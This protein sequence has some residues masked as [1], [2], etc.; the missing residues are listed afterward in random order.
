MPIDFKKTEKEFYLPKTSPTIVDIPEMV[1]IVVDGIGD[2]NTSAEYKDA[3]ET[4]YG[5]SY[6]IKMSKTQPQGHF[7]Y[8]VPPLEGLWW[9]DDKWFNGKKIIDKSKLHWSAMIR[10]PAFVTQDVFEL[11]KVVLAKKKPHINT[12]KA[13]LI[14]LTEGLCVQAM[15]IGSYDDEP[16]TV[17][18]ME[19][20]AKDS[21]F[22]IDICHS[23]R[24]HEIYISDPRK[25]ASNELKTVIRHPVKKA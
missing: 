10:Q 22:A 15:H 14:K 8:V 1:F 6:G 3:I 20:F 24:H 16:I 18:K 11:A 19:S 23:R 2:P 13:R 7:D 25:V 17:E 21:G 4:L 12:Q 9:G 5:L